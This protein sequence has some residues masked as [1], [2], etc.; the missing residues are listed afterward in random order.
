V[1]YDAEEQRRP[2]MHS[3]VGDATLPAGYAT[4]NGAALVYRGTEL[5]EAVTEAEG[6]LAYEVRRTADGTV[7]ERALP[8]RLLPDA[9]SG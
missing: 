2:L 4:D 3:L 1:H 6:A 8:T 7:S 9:Y 5:A